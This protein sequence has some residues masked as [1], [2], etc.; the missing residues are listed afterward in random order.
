MIFYSFPKSK[1]T[2]TVSYILFVK[3]SGQKLYE[4]Q[5]GNFSVTIKGA[6]LIY[7]IQNIIL[8]VILVIVIHIIYTAHSPVQVSAQIY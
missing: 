4:T 7:V 2:K 1:I 3:I 6:I 5:T 8:G